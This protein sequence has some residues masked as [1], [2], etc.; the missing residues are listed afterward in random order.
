MKT[1]LTKPTTAILISDRKL[2]HEL[3]YHRA[4][5]FYPRAQCQ[6]GFIVVGLG[7]KKGSKS[8][9]RHFLKYGNL[10]LR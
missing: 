9:I 7:S 5:I 2:Y 8:K 3:E 10:D 6:A 4:V 1:L